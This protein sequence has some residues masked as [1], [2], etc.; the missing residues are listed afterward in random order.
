M[1]AVEKAYEA[2]RDGIISGRYPPGTRITEQ[3]VAMLAGVSRTPVREALRQLNAEGLLEFVP[4]QGAVVTSWSRQ[5]LDEIFDLRAV[6]ESYAAAQ[7]ARHADVAVKK[8]L[9]KLAEQQLAASRER[10]PGHLAK[11]KTL[12]DKFH[13]E[14]A[15]AGGNRLLRSMLTT[16]TQSALATVTFRNYDPD[17][18]TRSARH[19]LELVSAIEA[20]DPEWA[21]SVMRSHILAARRVFGVE[22]REKTAS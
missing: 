21:A 8:R 12:N 16:L 15:K 1:K 6:L 20:G 18:L 14:I 4:N 11:I 13:R 9:R 19:H 2:V 7:A 22:V 3:E 17:S 5:E 10:E